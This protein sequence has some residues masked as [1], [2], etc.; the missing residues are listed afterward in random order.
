MDDP[1]R[2]DESPP[3]PSWPGPAVL[4]VPAGS[5]RALAKLAT[6]DAD[7][8]ILDLEDAVAPAAKDAAREA[9]R[10]ALRAARPR[11]P[12]AIRI[13]GLES[14]HITE[15]LLAAR[16]LMPD[17][18]VLPKAEAPDDLATLETALAE[19]DAPASLRLR[20][21]IETPRGVLAAERIAAHG[22][23]LS[24]LVVGTNDL[25][26]ATGVSVAPDRRHLHPWL[27]HV[28]LAAR[29]HGLAALDGVC[30]RWN[31][32]A[33]DAE[34]GEG[35]AMGFD[36]KTLIHPAQVA[37]TRMAFA[38]SGRALAEARAVVDAFAVVDGSVGVVQ[39]DGR[40]VER[41]HLDAARGLLARASGQRGHDA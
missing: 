16:A 23:R 6:L 26:A 37:P 25:V 8:L 29:A 20:A 3:V 33:F 9:L 19:T 17:A 40:M 2:A 22:G 41:L 27:M 11:V 31:E 12:Y 14:P 28:L 36:G 32:P 10:D 38:P 5:P 1:A 34:A 13:N 30:N 4:F 35:A 24:A 7:A 21:M 18:I 39:V 15:D